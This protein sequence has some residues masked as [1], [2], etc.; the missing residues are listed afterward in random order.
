MKR[1]ILCAFAL[2][3]ASQVC[4]QPPGGGAPGAAGG[5]PDNDTILANNDGDGDGQITRAEAEEAGVN[6]ITAWDTFDADGD[7]I[8]TVEEL[9]A[10]RAGA[11][12]GGGFGGGPGAAAPAPAADDAEEDEED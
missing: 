8:V 1:T 11:G 3:L 10:V 12:G 5:L 7:G 2:L 6:L 9:D 4:A